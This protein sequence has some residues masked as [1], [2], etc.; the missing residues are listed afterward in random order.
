[1]IPNDAELERLAERVVN[2]LSARTFILGTAESCTGGWVS[3]VLTEVVGSSAVLDRGFVTYSNDA[4]R[5][6]LGVP[7]ET[8]EAFGAVSSETAQAMVE[9]ALR[10][11]RADEVLAITGIAGPGGATDTKPVG[12]VFIA[13][14]GRLGDGYV[15]RAQFSGNR[16]AVRRQAV[17]RALQGVLDRLEDSET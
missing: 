8:L 10:H 7:A 6:M 5:E 9:G 12:T 2:E 3:K 14:G 4:K 1:V 13:W 11:S 16:E 15:E 17:A